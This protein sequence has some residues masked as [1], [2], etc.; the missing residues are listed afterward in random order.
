MDESFSALNKKYGDKFNLDDLKDYYIESI[1]YAEYASDVDGSYIT[2]S[3]TLNDYQT[4][5]SKL[6][7]LAEIA[8]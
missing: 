7:K 3:Q 4:S 5:I 2:Y 1:T 6:K 8:Y